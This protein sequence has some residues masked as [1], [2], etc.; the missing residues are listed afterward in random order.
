MEII[1]KTITLLSV[2]ALALGLT[3]AQAQSFAPQIPTPANPFPENPVATD[4]SPL[5][6]HSQ[7]GVL[8]TGRS[9]YA[10]LGGVVT[11]VPDAIG[12][13]LTGR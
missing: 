9:A 6:L 12:S 1:M 8:R 10:P 11:L 7:A 13:V 4:G 5:A 2:A 3:A